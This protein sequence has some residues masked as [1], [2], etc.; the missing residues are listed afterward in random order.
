M[1]FSRA[2]ASRRIARVLL[3][4]LGLVS[5]HAARLAA[6]DVLCDPGE[7]EVR[8]VQFNGNETF[9]DEDLAVR[10]LSTP[11][12]F[13]RRT[14]RLFGPKR[15]YPFGDVGG[16]KPVGLLND[17]NNLKTFY[18][19]NGFYDTR[20][21]TVLTH[22]APGRVDIAF[23]ITEGP[24]LI[25]DSLA[26]TGLDSVPE[27][28]I[29][30][31]D[32]VL[33]VGERFGAALA[34][35]QVDTLTTRLRDN[36]YPKATV[37][38]SFNTHPEEHRA[39]AGFDVVPGARAYFG[40]IAVRNV[41]I[42]GKAPRIDSSVI[43][44][45]LGFR[46]GDLYRDRALVDARR[47]LYDL[48]VFRHADV[49]AD[50]TWAHG[51]SIADV[52]VSVREDYLRLIDTEYGWGQLDC[53]KVAATYTNKNFQ[54]Q[55]RRLTLTTR[56]SKLG[57]AEGV[58]TDWSRA[59]CNRPYLYKDSLASS[60]VNYYAGATVTYP[61]L[62]G[63]PFTPSYSLYTERQG[64]YQ[65]Y[66]RTTE[67][68]LGVA[69][70]RDIARATPFRLGY[71]FEHGSTKAEPVVLCGVFSRCTAE[72]RDEVQRLQRLGIAS[73]SLQR[74]RTDNAVAPRAGY[75]AAVETRYSSKLLASDPSLEFFKVTGDVA[76]FRPVSRSV[77]FMARARG[78][79]I[80]GG[81][82]AN[83]ARLP[84]P[85]ER[86]YAGG[87]TTVRGFSQNQL[88]PQV[89]LMDNV[90]TVQLSDSTFFLV[91]ADENGV[92]TR[93]N[94]AVPGGG[95]LLAVFNMELRIR[96]RLL[97]DLLEY[98]PFIDAG[99]VWTTQIAKNVNRGPL[100]VTPGVGVRYFSPV[101]PVQ[102]NVGYNR[103][104]PTPGAAYFLTPASEQGSQKRPLLCV[105]P[106]G[107]DPVVITKRGDDLI[108]GDCPTTFSPPARGGFFRHL[109]FTVSIGTDF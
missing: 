108:Q 105:T 76:L 52:L 86:L 33:R 46:T 68:G 2:A 71:T 100:A 43:V 38:S 7:F 53:F 48:G 4:A 81:D 85:Q 79:I 63:L 5:M 99:Q 109:T 25:L 22:F 93:P 77:T 57:Y 16:D 12:S 60:K 6:Q 56:L 95:N 103:Y 31:R 89:Y 55:A 15:C 17:V 69:A 62:F 3:F 23:N 28:K 84:P 35:A 10:V 61:T 13:W 80:L 39:E 32:S 67:F 66:L 104:P 11:S 72:E 54:N 106:V 21:D 34:A 30:L 90:T 58:R 44:R 97:P 14:F 98:V 18:R 41:G 101:G 92:P 49:S 42:D 82:E 91:A 88:G 83:G 70:T 94:R 29:V 64:Q 59:L 75:V 73:A 96:D 40:N 37:F 51:D 20:I 8:S 65:A 45:M 9:S 36:G 27:R 102:V 50:S 74:I 107:Q 19:N 1:A 24:P 78:G 26:I 47:R 87:P